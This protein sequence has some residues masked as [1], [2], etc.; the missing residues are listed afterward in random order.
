MVRYILTWRLFGFSVASKIL[1]QGA[2]SIGESIL[3]TYHFL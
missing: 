3:V 2:I 1:S